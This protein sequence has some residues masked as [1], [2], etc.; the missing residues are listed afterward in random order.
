MKGNK[1]LPNDRSFE[2]LRNHYKVER[3]IAMR[4]KKANKE[5]RKII[6]KSMYDKLFKQVPDHPRAKRRESPK[7]AALENKRKYKLIKK[8][9]KKS[10]IFV[11]F[12]PGDCSFAMDICKYVRFA[13]GI[14][15]SDQRVQACSAP[16]NFKLIIYDGENL[17]MQENSVEI[18]FSN[19]LIEHLH[20]EDMKSHFKLVRRILKQ[21]GVYIFLTPHRF[22]GPH[23]IS[24]YFSDEAEGFHLKEWTYREIA[25][26]LKSLKYSSWSGYYYVKKIRIK[27]P[28][29]YF[30][31]IERVISIF[32]SYLRKIISKYFLNNI[33][34]LAVK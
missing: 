16:N 5:E 11:E 34:M 25:N 32:P 1:N 27:M 19:Q 18:V 12:G 4:L 8:F 9:I 23:D 10:G 13:Y 22:S 21:H 24:R 29:V 26:I 20:P 31:I 2:Q 17:E 7:I 28:F 6:Y 14:D 33:M 30:I 3:A 15:I